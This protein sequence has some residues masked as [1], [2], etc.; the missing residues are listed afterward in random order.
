[1]KYSRKKRPHRG[2]VR[3]SFTKAE[4]T[5]VEAASRQKDMRKKQYIREKALTSDGE[6][7]LG[8]N[9]VIVE[10]DVLCTWNG[11]VQELINQLENDELKKAFSLKME[12]WQ[13]QILKCAERPIMI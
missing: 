13:W 12:E 1:M 8:N 10:K 2:G 9:Q 5:T 4:N 11:E 7:I 6:P 3:T